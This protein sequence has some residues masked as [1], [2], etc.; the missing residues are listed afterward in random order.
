MIYRIKCNISL[1]FFDCVFWFWLFKTHSS[2]CW[3]NKKYDI[4]EGL[5]YFRDSMIFG[6]SV[7]KTQ[8]HLENQAF[9]NPYSHIYFHKLKNKAVVII[10][11]QT[12]KT[13]LW[14]NTVT[15]SHE[16]APNAIKPAFHSFLFHSYHGKTLLKLL[17]LVHG[18]CFPCSS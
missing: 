13:K 15:N 11:F 4:K 18:A 9:F 5:F 8:D 1:G 10:F 7:D 17:N 6:D 3:D 2:L 14:T 12:F 16:M